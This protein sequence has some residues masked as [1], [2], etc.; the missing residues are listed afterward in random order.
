VN[1]EKMEPDERYRRKKKRY[2]KRKRQ[3]ERSMLRSLLW[4]DGG[5]GYTMDSE[6]DDGEEGI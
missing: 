2:E 5:D 3:C 6:S 4:N 1:K